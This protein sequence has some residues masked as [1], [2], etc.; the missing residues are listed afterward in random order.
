VDEPEPGTLL[1]GVWALSLLWSSDGKSLAVWDVIR[2]DDPKDIKF[3]TWLVDVKT[4]KKTRLEQVPENHILD[5]WSRDGKCFLTT[6]RGRLH[7]MSRVGTEDRELLSTRASDG[8]LSPDGNKVLYRA[9]DPERVGKEPGL[10][11]LDIRSGKTTRVQGQPLNGES[12][13]YCWSPDGKRIAHAWRLRRD[14]RGE[15]ANVRNPAQTTESSL[16]VSDIDGQN[17]VNIATR[18]AGAGAIAI[19]E[20]DWR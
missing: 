2:A 4:Q 13:G 11:V 18:R 1:E 17:P 9:P 19:A 10:F 14:G 8:R 6:S 16:I 3:L 12:F 20:P 5:D 7:L 15:A